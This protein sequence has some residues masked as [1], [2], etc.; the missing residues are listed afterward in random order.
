MDS[1]YVPAP[2]E[3][4]VVYSAVRG[5]AGLVPGGESLFSVLIRAPFE[6]RLEEWMQLTDKRLRR[7]ADRIPSRVSTLQDDEAFASLFLSATQAAVK[8]HREDKRRL[9]AD[10]VEQ[11]ASGVAIEF[12]RQMLLMR[13]LDELTPSHVTLL[14]WIAGLHEQVEE[15]ASYP[16]LYERFTNRATSAIAADEFK[17]LCNDLAVRLL[18]RFS[19]SL[20]DFPGIAER[21]VRVTEDSG[22]GPKIVMTSLG[23]DLL[24]FVGFD[25]STA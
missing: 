22:R 11:S 7:L 17:L 16:A 3:A 13:F 18:V 25:L 20:E 5:I 19:E 23:M 9:L 2:D 12:D 8:A 1:P 14:Q 10:A 24:T 4:D 21:N 15:I 6:K